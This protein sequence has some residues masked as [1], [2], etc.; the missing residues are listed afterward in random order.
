MR[1]AASK[2]S[3][4]RIQRYNK[5][6]GEPKAL[7]FRLQGVKNAKEAGREHFLPPY[8]DNPADVNAPAALAHEGSKRNY[9]RCRAQ[10]RKTRC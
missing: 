9:Y 4:K 7:V 6:T 3:A 2:V 5:N 8:E 1:I 10:G